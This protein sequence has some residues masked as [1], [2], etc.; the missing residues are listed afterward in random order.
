MNDNE[1]KNK[2]VAKLTRKTGETEIS[3]FINLDGQGKADIDTGYK[4]FDHMLTLLSWFS[5]FD[6]SIK[7]KGNLLNQP[8]DHHIIE[9]IGITLG[10]AFR[11][12]IGQMKWGDVKGL[13]RYGSFC[14]PMDECL[15]MASVDIYIRGLAIVDLPVTKKV[16]DVNCS[17]LVH[18]FDAFCEEA[19]VIINLKTLSTGNEHHLFESAF[20]SLAK[21]LE[22]ATRI[23][24]RLLK[25]VPGKLLI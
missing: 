19:R 17:T 25:K 20:K 8:D 14:A 15:V 5:F 12:A 6:I 4:F 22:Q 3:V 11:K 21:A 18:F 24:P 23:D 7:V 16:G 13:S 1:F 2:R 10:Q 9:D